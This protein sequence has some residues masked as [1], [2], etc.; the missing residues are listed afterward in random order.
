[1]LPVPTNQFGILNC[2]HL[3]SLALLIV[4]IWKLLMKVVVLA[5]SVLYLLRVCKKVLAKKYFNIRLNVR[6]NIK[7]PDEASLSY[8][9]NIAI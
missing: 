9:H 1:M 6:F 2:Y 5:D 7:N 4:S 3:F 8:A